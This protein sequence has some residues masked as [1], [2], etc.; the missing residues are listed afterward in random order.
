[1]ATTRSKKS[2]RRSAK[3]SSARRTTA[4]RS[5]AKRTGSKRS[6]SRRVSAKRT[7]PKRRST[8]KRTGSKRS[9][10]RRLSAKRTSPKRRSTAR[11][12]AKRSTS[13][14]IAHITGSFDG[15]INTSGQLHFASG[16][17]CSGNIQAGSIQIDGAI[18]GSVFAR[19]QVK[20]GKKAQIKGKISAFKFVAE[21]GACFDGYFKLGRRKAA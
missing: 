13:S 7:S 20:L 11:K 18:K 12:S 9:S 21:E 19:N 3:R 15:N 2:R 4:K 1:M 5:A 16:A 10:S 6:S 17:K 14:K 8:A